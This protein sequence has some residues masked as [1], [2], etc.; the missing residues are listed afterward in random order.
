MDFFDMLL[1]I[2]EICYD[3][4]GM[5]AKNS[6]TTNVTIDDFK[7]DLQHQASNFLYFFNILSWDAYTTTM[8]VRLKK[9][10]A[11]LHMQKQSDI[12]CPL[13]CE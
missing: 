7:T 12:T 3:I 8:G 10:M 2:T 9:F 13:L 6:C 1:N 5:V 11:T 4:N